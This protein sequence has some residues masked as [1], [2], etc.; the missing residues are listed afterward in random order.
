MI[1]HLSRL[2]KIEGDTD[3]H[4]D[5]DTEIKFQ[6]QA[7]KNQHEF[8]D[9]SWLARIDETGQIRTGMMKINGISELL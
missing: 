7:K 2:E 8:N 6:I 9:Q 4:T 3:T 5:T 1:A